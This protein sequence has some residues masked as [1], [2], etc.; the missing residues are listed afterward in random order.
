VDEAKAATRQADDGCTVD[1]SWLQGVEIVGAT[2]NLD[3]LVLHLA[4][5]E[6]LTVQAALWK[7]TPFLAFRFPPGREPRA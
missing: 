3:S 6:T 7:G 5:G 2:S 4:S 1:W